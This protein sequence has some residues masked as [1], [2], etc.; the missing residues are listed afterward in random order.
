MRAN[1]HTDQKKPALQ[2]NITRCCIQGTVLVH[3]NAEMHCFRAQ[4]VISS[5]L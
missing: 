2:Q 1:L 4:H 5:I 3:S